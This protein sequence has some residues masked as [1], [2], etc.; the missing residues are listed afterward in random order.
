M[1]EVLLAMKPV[2]LPLEEAAAVFFG[3]MTV[4]GFLASAKI[5]PG[6]RVLV[7]GASGSVGTPNSGAGVFITG[8]P[9][10]A[11]NGSTVFTLESDDVLPSVFIELG[12]TS[13][14]IANVN[15]GADA[16][17]TFYSA[18]FN[19]QA[20]KNGAGTVGEGRERLGCGWIEILCG[21]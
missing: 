19:L 11:A 1:P 10:V 21:E 14:N 17:T 18:G 3:G 7:Y 16:G 2:N 6:D 9:T 13:N 8:G 5:Q 20:G 4:L 15:V 12:T